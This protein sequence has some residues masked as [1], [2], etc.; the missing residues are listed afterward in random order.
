MN[1]TTTHDLIIIGAGLSGLS[2]AHYALRQ[3]WQPLLLEAET[4]YGGALHSH[5]FQADGRRFWAELGG[6]TAFNSY[7]NMLEI[8]ERLNKLGDLRPRDTRRFKLLRGGQL[9]SI[10]GQLNFLQLLWS[11]PRL[12]SADKQGKTVAEYYARIFGRDNYQNL[13]AHAFNAVISQPAGEFP[14]DLLFRKKPRRKDVQRSFVLPEGMQGVTDAM[15]AELGARCLGG[16]AVQSI[17]QDPNGLWRVTDRQGETHQAQ[18]LILAT[19]ADI[20]ANLLAD[21]RPQLAALLREI[22]MVSIETL[23]L[24]IP[25]AKLK[26]PPLAGVIA[27]D[28][29][30]YSLVSRDTLHDPQWR[31]LT[32]HFRPGALSE[33]EKIQRIS[34]LLGLRPEDIAATASKENRLPALRL[35]HH[36][37]VA[38]LDAQL[39]GDSLGLSGNYFLGV[40]MEDCVS[41]SRAEFER[42]L[43]YSCN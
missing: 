2:C 35:G 40:S 39:Q 26:L 13:F 31:A 17:A 3:D 23:S 21:S 42:L 16:R 19:P 27:T 24:L 41:R 36:Q 18:R 5:D 37:R 1:A 29:A 8:L 11:L 22:Q 12:F 7:G 10:P 33:A 25:A 15:A 38:E 30:F 34:D 4:R 20:A 32:F 43:Q 6:H 28:E 9:R 14:A